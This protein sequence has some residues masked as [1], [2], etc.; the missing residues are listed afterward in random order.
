MKQIAIIGA[1]SWGTAMA[2]VAARAGHD[3]RLWS[4]NAAVVS[5]INEQRVNLR[6]LSSTSVP[7]GVIATDDLG[8]ALG[9]SAI[10]LIAVP[11]HAARETLNATATSL[12]E[13]AI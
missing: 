11:S 3:V 6:H 10:V 1:G 13:N 7:D 12:D 8:A 2:V 4:R 5:S 9:G